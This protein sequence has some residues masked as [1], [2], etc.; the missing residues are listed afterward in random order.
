M[1][2]GCTNYQF[3]NQISITLTFGKNI[4]IIYEKS[5][6]CCKHMMFLFKNSEW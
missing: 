6:A 2:T 5:F 1:S 4:A 3:I